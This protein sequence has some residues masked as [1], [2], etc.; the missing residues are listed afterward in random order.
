MYD[1]EEFNAHLK[2]LIDEVDINPVKID[3][4][5]DVWGATSEVKKA[6]LKAASQI[7]GQ[8]DKHDLLIGT[9]LILLA[10]VRK[11]KAVDS[12]NEKRRRAGIEKAAADL[13]P[14]QTFGPALNGVTNG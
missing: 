13:L 7:K 4:P 3:F 14:R 9:L 11:R 6:V 2:K 1:K 12:V 5:Q 8:D 10:H